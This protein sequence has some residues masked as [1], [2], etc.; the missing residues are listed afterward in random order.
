[1][2]HLDRILKH[3]HHKEKH[4]EDHHHHHH[5]KPQ[6]QSK[7]HPNPSRPD[8]LLTGFFFRQKGT[9]PA[10]PP[11]ESHPTGPRHVFA[12]FIVRTP[13]LVTMRFTSVAKPN[14]DWKYLFHHTGA[15]GV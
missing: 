6:S 7:Y 8:S 14:P 13:L 15:M 12:H 3:V 5:Q 2:K 9:S 1:M 11:P 10:T 4:H